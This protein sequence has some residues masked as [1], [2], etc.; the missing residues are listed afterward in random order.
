MSVLGN[1]L[2]VVGILLLAATFYLGYE[3]YVSISVSQFASAQTA[4]SGASNGSIGGAIGGLVSG[5]VSSS[6]SFAVLIIKVILLFLFANIGYKF[7]ALGVS[8]NRAASEM[9][10]EAQD[11]KEA[12]AGEDESAS[13][14]KAKGANKY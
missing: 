9:A 6:D 12:Q 8:Q 5:L 2:V 10:R 1:S 3:F 4:P 11:E 14:P 13:K 7:A